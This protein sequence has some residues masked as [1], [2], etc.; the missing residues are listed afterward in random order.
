MRRALRRNI[1]W[2]RDT[3]FAQPPSTPQEEL[4]FGLLTDFERVLAEIVRAADRGDWARAGELTRAFN[5]AHREFV[6]DVVIPARRRLA[7]V[8]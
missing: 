5:E 8:N 2:L 3:F 1:K 7:E 4:L 6:N